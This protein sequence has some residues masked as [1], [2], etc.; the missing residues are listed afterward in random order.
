MLQPLS[1]QG[2]SKGCRVIAFDRP[3]YGL[4]ERPLTWPAGPEGNPYTSEV[5]VPIHT[6]CVSPAVVV[7]GMVMRM[8]ASDVV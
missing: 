4:S 6:A 1:E 3:P 5:L 8:L 7:P 2:G